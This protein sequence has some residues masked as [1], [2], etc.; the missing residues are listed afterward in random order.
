M[1][2]LRDVRFSSDNC[3][4]LAVR[5]AARH[6]TQHYDRYLASAGLRITQFS[7]LAKLKRLGPMSINAL[8]REMVMNRTTL[9]RNILPLERDGLIEVVH[10]KT[11]RRR[12]DVLATGAGIERLNQAVGAWAEAQGAFADAF[13]PER[14]AELRGILKSVS[15]TELNHFDH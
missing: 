7:I 13:G 12:K 11:D 3:T 1:A 8:A 2:S 10:S 4:C 5:Q 6:V 9:A 14:T 15:G